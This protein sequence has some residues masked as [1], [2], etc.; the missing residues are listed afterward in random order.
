[1]HSKAKRWRRAASVI[2]AAILVGAGVTAC[3]SGSAGGGEQNTLKIWWWENDDSALAAA[4]NKSIDI[5]KK[6]HPDV[7]VEFE[8]KTYEQMQQSGQLLLDSNDAPDVLEYLKGNATA[9]VVS[10]AGLLTDLTDVAEKRGWDLSSTAQ[11]VGLY[12]EGIMGSGERYGITNYGEY[13]PVWYNKDLFD[14]YGLE[15]PK[16]FDEFEHVLQTFVDNGITPLALGSAD[17]P[18][19]HL[20]YQLALTHMDDAD[21]SAYQQFDGDVNWDAWEKA[22]AAVQDWTKK[23]YISTDSTGIAAQDAGNAFVAGQYPIFFSGTWWAGTFADQIKDFTFDQFL[24]PGADRY[25]G[26]G[27]NLWVVPTKAHNKDLAY[28]FLEITMSPEI[29]N[30]LGNDG[31]VPVAA[32]ESA[33]TTP[34]G[35]LTTPRFNELLSAKTG[36]LGWY[37]DWPVAGMNDVLIAQNTDLV[38]GNVTPKQ[39]VDKI[40]AAYE[41]GA[42]G[43]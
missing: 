42:P 24:F 34:I 43:N 16:T 27:G 11:D 8:L 30:M 26:S 13:V 32:D 17:Y 9:G 2:A 19:P 6:Q 28:D 23:G 37:P 31:G 21:W 22:A 29:Q 25:P 5:F 15:V 3:S 41:Q 7:K 18:G 39:A 1:M 10:K 40:R 12:S 33:I 35:K 36:G 20:L 38:L 4:W 14:E